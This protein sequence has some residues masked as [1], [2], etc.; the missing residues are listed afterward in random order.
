MRR[1]WRIPRIPPGP[2]GLLSTSVHP[3]HPLLGEPSSVAKT[4]SLLPSRRRHDK[5]IENDRCDRKLL[6]IN[7]RRGTCMVFFSPFQSKHHPFHTI[8]TAAAAPFESI[9]CRSRAE[10][11]PPAGAAHLRTSLARSPVP[12][13]RIEDWRNSF[14]LRPPS[15]SR[16]CRRQRFVAVSNSAGDWERVDYQVRDLARTLRGDC[17]ASPFYRVAAVKAIKSSRDTGRCIP[18]RAQ[19]SNSHGSLS[20]VCASGWVSNSSA[21]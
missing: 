9:S 12:V 15:L 16:F 6:G 17:A 3:H 10:I 21:H 1:P 8:H 13:Q 7:R 2:P 11:I 14:Q 19:A 4:I 5:T 20:A 18:T